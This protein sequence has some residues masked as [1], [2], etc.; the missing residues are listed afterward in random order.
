MY[1]AAIITSYQTVMRLCLTANVQCASTFLLCTYSSIHITFLV[2]ALSMKIIRTQLLKLSKEHNSAWSFK[3]LMLWISKGWI[4]KCFVFTANSKT[5]WTDVGQFY[6]WI[7][8]SISS[9]MPF[10]VMLSISF[11]WFSE[12]FLLL[13]L[14]QFVLLVISFF[15]LTKLLFHFRY[16]HQNV[17]QPEFNYYAVKGLFLICKFVL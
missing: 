16:V 9:V 12:I 3:V 13:L 5:W 8:H 7:K 14:Y 6:S 15:F 11:K 17:G 10:T 4:A 1:F 2:V